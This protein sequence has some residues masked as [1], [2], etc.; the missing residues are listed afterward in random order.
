MYDRDSRRLTQLAVAWQE[1]ADAMRREQLFGQILS[2]CMNLPIV[3][4]TRWKTAHEVCGQSPR[5]ADD[6][7]QAVRR[8]VWRSLRRYDAEFGVPFDKYASRGLRVAI[9]DFWKVGSW[10]H[11]LCVHVPQADWKRWRS[12]ETRR[13]SGDASAPDSDP[14][15]DAACRFAAVWD[16]VDMLGHED[17]ENEGGIFDEQDF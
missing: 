1:E 8:A 17:I 5:F 12:E 10:N 9:N 3:K 6:E 4:A 15:L 11:D 16:E 13:A 7:M 2:R 14:A